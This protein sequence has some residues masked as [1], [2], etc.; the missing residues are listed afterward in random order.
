MTEVNRRDFVKN[1]TATAA[2]A[3]TTGALFSTTAKAQGANGKIRVAVIGFGWRGN[4]LIQAVNASDK[5][6]LVAICDADEKHLY[7]V[8]PDNKNLFRTTDLREILD[9]NDVDAIASATP[10]HWH[11]LLTVWAC[12]AG[13][14]VYMEK[15][16][17]HN[18]VE[19]DVLV[20]ASRK[21]NKIVQAG[22]QNRSDSGLLPFYERLH[23]GDFGKVLK[24][25]GTTNRPRATIGKLDQPAAPPSTVNYD[26][27][28]GPAEDL[29]LMRPKFHYDWHWDFNTGNGDIGN[30]SAH[31]ID[32]INW[33]LKDPETLPQSIQVAGNRFG[34][35]DAGT[36]PNVL[37]CT[38][39]HGGVPVT[40]ELQDLKGG[41]GA[42]Y[43]KSVGVILT[44]EKGV[45]V[46]GRGGGRYVGSDGKSIRFGKTKSGSQGADGGQDHMDNFFEAILTDNRAIQASEA[47]PAAISASIA[48]MAN[49]SF[50]LGDKVPT[51]TIEKAFSNSM[52]ERDTLARMRE[53]V[54]MFAAAEHK[55]LPTVDWL[56]GPKLTF[57]SEAYAF[58]GSKASEANVLMGRS[59]RKGFELPAV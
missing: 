23:A 44:M 52:P 2:V 54:L 39:E 29:L 30:Q 35:H 48:H 4:F 49:I 32:L 37:A 42:P 16:I 5:A 31:E 22:F 1:A 28:L 6:E 50:L 53:S 8:E 57:D 40:F 17:S 9:R 33:A 14:H 55:S 13:K 24:A 12:Q 15:P 11:A 36:T 26:M 3:A 41:R 45:F 20:K 58:T 25:H 56:L 34:W 19:S 46:G 47:A 27:W 18:M 7:G 21:H 38:Y 10:N 51:E 43:R 59:Y